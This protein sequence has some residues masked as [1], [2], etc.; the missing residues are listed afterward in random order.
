M[1]AIG[2]RSKLEGNRKWE[3]IYSL[4]QSSFG[5]ERLS[6]QSELKNIHD[7]RLWLLL[8]AMAIFIYSRFEF[9]LSPFASVIVLT[10]FSLCRIF[11]YSSRFGITLYI[12]QK[13][14]FICCLGAL[15]V[16]CLKIRVLNKNLVELE[17][18]MKSNFN[19]QDIILH[20]II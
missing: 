3:S 7:R 8:S 18:D 12:H 4:S 15:F 20:D 10:S 6:S 9:S 17:N 2:R 1:A 16:A 13:M 19:Q 11:N 5:R 14:D